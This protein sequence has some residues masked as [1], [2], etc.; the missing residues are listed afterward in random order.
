MAYLDWDNR[1]SVNHPMLDRHNRQ[2]LDILNRLHDSIKE[3]RGT[4]VIEKILTDLLKHTKEHFEEEERFL[5][6]IDFPHLE[7][8]KSYHKQFSDKLES[9]KKYVAEGHTIFVAPQLLNVCV[10]WLHEHILKSDAEY[11]NQAQEHLA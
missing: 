7:N 6:Q 1:F 3:D 10:M 9:F 5:I 4:E 2:M 11:A 8:H